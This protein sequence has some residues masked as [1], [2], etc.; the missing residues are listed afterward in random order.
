MLQFRRLT[1]FVVLLVI[2]GATARFPWGQAPREATLRLSWR[3]NGQEI[4]VPLEQDPG[5]PAHMRL[6][7]EQAYKVQM[8]SYILRVVVDDRRLIDKR[9]DPA[10]LRHDRPLSVFEE[11]PI[12]P[13]PHRLEVEFAPENLAGAAPPEK[14]DSCRVQLEFHPGGVR[15]VTLQDE[16]QWQVK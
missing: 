8:R 14:V 16:G 3:S 9:V 12:S 11:L 4:R 7:K 2:L 6:P 13:G 15:L 5:L 10:G 1:G